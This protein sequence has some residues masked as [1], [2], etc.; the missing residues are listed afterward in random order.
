MMCI[1]SPICGRAVSMEKDGRVYSCDHFVDPEYCLGQVGQDV[2]LSDLVR[3]SR[4]RE[5]GEAKFASLP[6]F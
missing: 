3:S 2:G 4:Q 6:A 1:C 5:F